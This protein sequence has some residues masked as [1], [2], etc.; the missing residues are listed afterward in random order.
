[1]VSHQLNGLNRGNYMI[2]N[3]IFQNYINGSKLITKKVTRQLIR[4]RGIEPSIIILL[5]TPFTL[6]PR[7]FAI[8]FISVLFLYFIYLLAL[9]YNEMTGN[10]VF[11]LAY[12]NTE[13]GQTTVYNNVTISKEPPYIQFKP[14]SQDMIKILGFDINELSVDGKEK[15]FIDII[16]VNGFYK[17]VEIIEAIK[18]PLNSRQ[19]F[20]DEFNLKSYRLNLYSQL[21]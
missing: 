16:H 7:L 13:Y 20:S 21:K 1:M 8:G 12:A 4:S 11:R 10:S 19:Q 14:E 2:T 15:S 9:L 18:K 6:L 5:M 17:K 3:F